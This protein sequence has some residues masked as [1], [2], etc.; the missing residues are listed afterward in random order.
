[1]AITRI[2]SKIQITLEQAQQGVERLRSRDWIR[3][4]KMPGKVSFEVTPKGKSVL[5]ACAKARRARITSQLEQAIQQQRKVKQRTNFLIRMESFEDKWKNYKV[6]DNSQ[7]ESI[8]LEGARLLTETKEAR[9]KQPFCNAN[10][11]GYDQEFQRFKTQIENL[12]TQNNTLCK[13]VN[14]CAQ[15][16]T[17]QLAITADIEK[18]EKAIVKYEPEPDTSAH[19]NAL[20]IALSKLKQIQA[21]LSAFEDIQL[22]RMEELRTKLG[23]NIEILGA[24]RKPTHE[25]ILIKREAST[26]K[27]A[28]YPDPEL[29]IKHNRQTSSPLEE[30]CVKCGAKRVSTPVNIG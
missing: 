3:K 20:K 6:P 5:E 14:N 22:V 17:S 12:T 15:I 9:D 26:E 25:F 19:I 7:M 18:M 1:M 29:P 23:E 4:Y 28:L 30:K 16:K 21:Q 13:A 27:L 10:P 11:E 24:L 8:A 2:S